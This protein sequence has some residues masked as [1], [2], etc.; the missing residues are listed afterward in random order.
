MSR[1]QLPGRR[2]LGVLI[3]AV[4]VCLGLGG[5]VVRGFLQGR[6]DVA[7]EAEQDQPVAPPERVSVVDGQAVVTIAPKD[8]QT[9]G[10]RTASL[11]TAVHRERVLAY[12]R[13][14]DVQPLAALADSLAR[15]RAQLEVARA[16]LAA[17]QTAY[18][19]AQGLYRDQHNISAAQLQ[20]AEAEFRVDQAGATAAETERQTLE[21]SAQQAWGPA[22]GNAVSGMTPLFTRLLAQ[23]DVLIQVT[24]RPGQPKVQPAAGA[25]VRLDDETQVPLAFVSAATK[26]DPRVQ[27]PGFLFTA[28]G[29]S[30]LLPG[31]SV[32]AFLSGSKTAVAA[33]IPSSAVVWGQG[34]AWAYFRTGPNTF[35]RRAVPTGWPAPTDGYIVRNQQQGAELVVEGAQMLFSEEFRSQLQAG[36]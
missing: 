14:L 20:A 11:Q 24:L 8:Q 7:R 32:D 10:I 21:L 23:E 34:R 25:F 35:A 31:M 29:R 27:G 19:R 16:K 28:P 9:D 22:L 33:V 4:I 1:R 18:Q 5:F 12:G 3:A 36:D 2:R 6:G 30:G 13:V 17:A 15:A 26:A